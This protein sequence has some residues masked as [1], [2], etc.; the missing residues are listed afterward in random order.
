M[1]WTRRRVLKGASCVAL[2]MSCAPARAQR[3]PI[4]CFSARAG[5]SKSARNAIDAIPADAQDGSGVPQ[6]VARVE[7][8]LGFSVQIEVFLTKNR[9]DNA[10]ATLSNGRKLLVIDPAFM[11]EAN[12]T[13]GTDWA[14][15]EIIAHEIGHHIASFSDD[16]YIDELNADYWSGQ[17]LQRLGSSQDA[18]TKSM[19]ALGDP[20]DTSTHPNRRRRATMVAQGWADAKAD[21]INWSHCDHCRG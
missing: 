1:S 20:E 7:Q 17:T 4:C 8:S 11:D 19:L 2:A 21:V 5:W 3:L 18:A 6:I 16:S 15:V 10:F 13:S 12:R 14:A 9:E